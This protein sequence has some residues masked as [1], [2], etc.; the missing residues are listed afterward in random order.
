MNKP[1]KGHALIL[2][3]IALLLIVV[4]TR[5]SAVVSSILAAPF[6]VHVTIV[7][8]VLSGYLA[9]RYSVEDRKME[10]KWIEQEGEVFIRRMEEEKERKNLPQG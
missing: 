5:E 9:L 3:I 6:W 7:G 1:K 4:S 8:I 10:Q 2:G